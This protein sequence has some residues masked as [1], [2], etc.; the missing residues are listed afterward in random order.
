MPLHIGQMPG[1]KLL[2][3]RRP[4]QF[5]LVAIAVLSL[6]G[7]KYEFANVDCK[8]M[9]STE[10][11]VGT[12]KTCKFR[13]DWGD[14][15]KYTVVVTRPPAHGQATGEGKYLKYVAKPSFRGEDRLTIRV[16]RRGIA[17]IG[18]QQWETLSLKVTVG[19]NT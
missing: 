10:L 9:K 14:T 2:K 19:A 13:Y 4:L 18:Q 3:C 8:K 5:V 16:E 6:G 1:G 12:G 17:G 15:A 11:H 7:C